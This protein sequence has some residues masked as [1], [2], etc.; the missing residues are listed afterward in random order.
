LTIP[1]HEN[2]VV[3]NTGTDDARHEHAQVAIKDA[4]AAV[5]RQVDA[6]AA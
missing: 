1:S 5:R 6:L 4:F 3:N 2:I